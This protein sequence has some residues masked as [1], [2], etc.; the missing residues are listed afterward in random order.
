V[1]IELGGST[2]STADVKDLLQFMYTGR[3]QFTPA[4]AMGLLFLADYYAILSIKKAAANFLFDLLGRQQL[5]TL[6][7]IAEQ[8]SLK[9]LRLRCAR[10]L[11]EDF[12][13][14]L[15]NGALW[16]IKP[17]V[18][19]ELLLQT[20]LA[21][22]TEGCVLDAVVEYASRQ[23][24]ERSAVLAL[25]LPCVRMPQLGDRLLEL[26]QDSELMAVPGVDLL[27]KAAMSK[28]AFPGH[29]IHNQ[30]PLQDTPRVGLFAFGAND[31]AEMVQVG[32]KLRSF[33]M[34]LSAF[35]ATNHEL[36]KVMV[37]PALTIGSQLHI[38]ADAMP[39]QFF[40]AAQ[41]TGQTLQ[42][43]VLS[44]PGLKMMKQSTA[45]QYIGH[46]GSTMSQQ[47]Q[48]IMAQQA[49]ACLNIGYPGLGGASISSRVALPR[50]QS[51]PNSMCADGD[52][53]SLLLSQGK[54]QTGSQVTL[55]FQKNGEALGTPLTWDEKHRLFCIVS[56]G[57]PSLQVPYM[58]DVSNADEAFQ[59]SIKK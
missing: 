16:T 19:R 26:Q 12:D 57:V 34:P 40:T 9:N 7:Q 25:L 14:L 49:V 38:C 28:L 4:N 47:T 10:V 48:A 1:T 8:Y 56:L 21:V 37:E 52:I 46:A 55:T 5:S 2:A 36:V 18:W 43:C 51:L 58:G 13:E 59:F 30:E 42:I 45:T 22:T 39:A 17:D 24:E 23:G 3:L 44:E 53:F 6:L 15:D 27:M 50:N 29:K 11:A 32:E 31:I 41:S 33:K 54:D 35:T 20:D